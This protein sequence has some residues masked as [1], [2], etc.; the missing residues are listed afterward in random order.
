[1]ACVKSKMSNTLPRLGDV[2]I[3]VMTVGPFDEGD[4]IV[5]RKCKVVYIN[6]TKGWYEVEFID[7]GIKECYS[8]PT[9]DHSI[10]RDSDWRMSPVVCVETG[11]VYRSVLDCA[12]DMN[13]SV[14]D[15]S[16]CISGTR[17]NCLGYHF[18]TVL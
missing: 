10:L 14:K 13:L 17:D 11:Y 6:N 15:I 8:I 3:R 12:K 7:N 1:M 16:K 5:P 4:R 2:L 18:D 9:F